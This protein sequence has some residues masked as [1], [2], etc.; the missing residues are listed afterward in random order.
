[1]RPIRD[2]F[3][4]LLDRGASERNLGLNQPVIRLHRPILRHQFQCKIRHKIEN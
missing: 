1:M 3:G 2:W 4:N